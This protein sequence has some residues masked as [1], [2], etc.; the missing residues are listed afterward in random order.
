MDGGK[1]VVCL[2]I[3]VADVVGRPLKALPD[4]GRL[5]LVDEMSLHTGGCAINTA[6]ALARLDVP[7][8]VTGRIGPDA[9]GDFLLSELH[10]RG[11]G[12]GSVS[13]DPEI[14]TSVT[15]VMVDTDGERRFVHCIGANARL[16]LEDVD[17]GVIE[18]ASIVHVAGALVLPG[19]DGEPTAE[20]LG[21]ARS[22]G[23]TTFLD[24]VWDDTGQW[25]RLLEPCLPYVDYFVPS[26]TEAQAL[27]GRDEPEDIGRALLDHG[28]GTVGLKMG[29][30][31]CLVMTDTG[32]SLRMPAFEVNV[33]DATGAGDAFAAG[34][35]AG[36]WQGWSLE[37]TARLA[38]AVGALCVTGLGATGGV[39]SLPETMAFMESARI[40]RTQEIT[41]NPSL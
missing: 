22:M 2:G 35:I 30:A 29:A 25:M 6:T 24:T 20:L 7:V 21:R 11:I 40:R 9:F 34:F 13:R 12:V 41:G 16:T 10:S 31:G 26:L 19:M 1:S 5:V 14:G 38:N 15:M 23:V 28:V 4:R 32:E 39:R 27:T 33:M 17:W 18:R 36:V 3:L 37:E 8:E